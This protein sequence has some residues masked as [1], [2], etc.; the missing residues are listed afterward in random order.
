M[1]ESMSACVWTACIR[2]LFCCSH[3]VRT[4]SLKL[5]LKP[6]YAAFR[7]RGVLMATAVDVEVMTTDNRQQT[8]DERRHNRRH[9]TTDS[10]QQITD[11][12]AVGS[13]QKR[14][15]DKHCRTVPDRQTGVETGRQTGR[16]TDR[17][18]DREQTD[19]SVLL[20]G[21]VALGSRGH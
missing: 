19:S 2:G 6:H 14:Q 3:R 5:N 20:M 9:Q 12:M 15:K 21:G 7:G 11:N 8:A 10:R 17:Q 18:R 13:A 1:G 16:Q 4:A